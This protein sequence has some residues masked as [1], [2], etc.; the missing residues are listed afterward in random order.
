MTWY[1]AT[2]KFVRSRGL[3]NFHSL[4]LFDLTPTFLTVAPGFFND[5]LCCHPTVSFTDHFGW[6]NPACLRRV[7]M[8]TQDRATS[9]PWEGDEIV[10]SAVAAPR[11]RQAT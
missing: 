6:S 11:G 3:R 7:K 10:T 9:M 2:L 8:E 1:S 5:S 4:S